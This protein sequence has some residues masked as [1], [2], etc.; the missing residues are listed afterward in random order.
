MEYDRQ[1]GL[2][3]A[4]LVRNGEAS[5]AELVEIAINRLERLNPT[6]NAAIT[7]IYDRAR[8]Q[9]AEPL[10]GPFAGVPFLVKDLMVALP[11]VRM[12]NGSRAL[13]SYV[14]DHE[15]P[16]A[17][18]IREA[19]FVTIAT[20]NCAELGGSA[21]TN[22][23]A[24]GPTCNPWRTQLNSGG[25]SGGSTAAVAARIVPMAS[26]SDGGGSIRLPAS[27]CGVFGF[28]PGRGV[29][30]HDT[31]KAW[32]G[33]I[34]SHATTV[35]VRDSAAYLDWTAHRV[36]ADPDA[37]VPDSYLAL[38]GMAPRPLRI[39]MCVDSPA[40]RAVHG[41][42]VAAVEDAGRLLE[43][44]GHQVMPC[45]LPYD[46]RALLR[47]LMT[48]IAAFTARDV[49]EMG[50]WLGR[51]PKGLEIGTRM[52]A[53]LGAGIGPDRLDAALAE[54]RRAAAAMERFHDEY[55]LLLTPAAATPPLPHGAFD[56][57]PGEL[58]GMELLTRLRL[59]RHLFGDSVCDQAI[60]KVV[61][62]FAFTPLA[63]AT[64]QPAMSVPLYW[65]G[66]GLPIGVQFVGPRG[67]EGLLFSLA[68]QLEA[69][70]PWRDRRPPLCAAGI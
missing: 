29:N 58:V 18:A 64:G 44:L 61:H 12:T 8:Q 16:Q 2:G 62:H 31:E 3:L 50:T 48:V 56:F 13:A 30:P 63:N 68:G 49:A 47:G 60:D 53:E 69:A 46:G 5:A 57:S 24:F 40:G 66:D 32:G 26:S 33:A 11:G 43:A 27:Y 25:S 19:G 70:R 55:D 9:A 35:S 37:P 39:A 67:G 21:L 20:T 42:C 51:K 14:P 34:V 45:P 7:M 36:A 54:W 28:K 15:C 38:A 59:G 4:R 23:Q 6:L 52:F 22:P 1:D 10:A 41:D 65:S 17:R